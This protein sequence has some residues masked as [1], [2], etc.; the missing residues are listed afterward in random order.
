MNPTKSRDCTV[1]EQIKR[2]STLS[3][4]C[5]P[6]TP[7]FFPIVSNARVIQKRYMF[8]HLYGAVRVNYA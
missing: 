2:P 1:N 7:S 6:H 8:A 5:L 3:L 4:W